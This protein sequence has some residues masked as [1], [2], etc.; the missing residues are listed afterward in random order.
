[1]LFKCNLF[2]SFKHKNKKS[3][4]FF[5]IQSSND[6]WI[7]TTLGIIFSFGNVSYFCLTI[8]NV[9]GEEWE[10]GKTKLLKHAWGF[11]E[12][13]LGI[14]ICLEKVGN[15]KSIRICFWASVNSAQTNFITYTFNFTHRDADNKVFIFQKHLNFKM[16]GDPGYVQMILSPC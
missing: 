16:N 10:G 1:M 13:C 2:F 9:G 3:L 14:L 8:Q 12:N 6:Y 15:P 11:W 5:E 4:E 7:K